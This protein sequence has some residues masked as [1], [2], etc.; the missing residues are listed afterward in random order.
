MQLV[1]VEWVDAWGT[2]GPLSRKEA[3]EYG[4]LLVTTGGIL[5]NEDEEVV[6]VAQDYWSRADADG[7]V[8]ETFRDISV[9]PKVLVKKMEIIRVFPVITV[10]G[11]EVERRPDRVGSG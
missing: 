6:R 3:E 1:Y 11:E 9:I 2:R 7:T 4:A 8:P 10:V 5:V